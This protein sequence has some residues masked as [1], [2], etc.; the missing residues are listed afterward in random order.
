MSLEAIY[1]AIIDDP[2][3]IWAKKP[4]Y[5]PLY[6]VSKT[7]KIVIIGQAPGIKAQKSGIPWDDKSGET[8]RLWLGVTKEQFYDAKL[9]AIIPMDFYYPGKGLHGDLPPR[10]DIAP[11]WHPK[12]LTE[13]ENVQLTIL[14][15]KYAQDYYLGK[16]TRNN[17]T[18]TVRAY[19]KYLPEYF[20]LVHPS[21]L[22]FRWQSKNPWFEHDVIPELQQRVKQICF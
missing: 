5:R 12:I 18:E 20:P 8:L 17:L 14:I 6:Q 2:N 11:L 4:G 16:D 3:N 15:G 1:N 22:N 7:S 21:P 9:F 13:L 19:E 10:K